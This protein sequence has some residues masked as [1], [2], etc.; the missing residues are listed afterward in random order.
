MSF[1][2]LQDL[3]NLEKQWYHICVFQSLLVLLAESVVG[4]LK[5]LLGV[6]PVSS[7]LV[8]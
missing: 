7:G 8:S 3:I 4:S 2:T 6:V 5:H 1:I